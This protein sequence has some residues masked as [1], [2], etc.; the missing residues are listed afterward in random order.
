VK[1]SFGVDYGTDFPS[2]GAFYDRQSRLLHCRRSGVE[3]SS[4][5]GDVIC[6]SS[7]FPEKSQDSSFYRIISVI[8]TIY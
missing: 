5:F 8:A 1:A 6:V 7:G 4:A 2:H 3:W